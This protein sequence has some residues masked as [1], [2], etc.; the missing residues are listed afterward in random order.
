MDFTSPA[1]GQNYS[2]G[3]TPAIIANQLDL[4]KLLDSA[5]VT[6]SAG[7]VAGVKRYNSTNDLFEERNAGNTAWQEMPLAYLKLAGGTLTGG[8]TGTT[9][10]F[11]TSLSVNSQAV[12]HAGNFTPSSKQDALGYTAANVA[13]QTYT[14][15]H[16]FAT[17][18]V[19]AGNN[20]YHSGNFNPANYAALSGATFT[21]ACV[22]QS[23]SQ[24]TY[25]S[26]AIQAYSGAGDVHIAFHAGGASACSL[27][28]VR[29]GNGLILTDTSGS[30]RANFDAAIIYAQTYHYSYGNVYAQ[31]EVY[32]YYSDERLKESITPL[33]DAMGQVRSLNGFRYKINALGKKLLDRASDDE[34][35]LGLSAQ[36]VQR[37][38]PEV[39]GLAPFDLDE[40]TGKSKSGDEYLTVQY[41]RMVPLLVEALKEVDAR[42]ARLEVA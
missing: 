5:T 38:A 6:I 15:T 34:W 7:L 13:G 14:G 23:N 2:S 3:Y 24:T 20:V 35:H 16:V 9:A 31:G 17:L 33:S 42:V 39:V 10:N 11:T 41:E 27:K 36:A 26:A 40:K 1:V 22:F 8:L 29:T 30:T 4:A 32:A 25:S 18:Q 28:H 12:W 19:G 37:I 21:A